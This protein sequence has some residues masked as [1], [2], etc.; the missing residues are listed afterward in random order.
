[1][2]LPIHI[3]ELEGANLREGVVDIVERILEDMSLCEPAM[4]GI[5]VFAVFLSLDFPWGVFHLKGVPFG[6][7][8]SW[9]GLRVS[10]DPVLEFI[11]RDPIW[12]EIDGIGK[13]GITVFVRGVKEKIHI[14]LGKELH[15]HRVD[16]AAFHGRGSIFRHFDVTGFISLETMSKLVGQ[17]IDVTAGAIEVREDNRAF[18]NGEISHIATALLPWLG[19][20]EEKMVINH[21]VEEIIGVGA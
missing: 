7:S 15:G 12:E 18:M 14:R 21:E 20:K 13:M 17:D 11:N 2:V 19:V 16:F 8:F 9:G 1:V 4:P 5:K 3:E 6:I 10:V